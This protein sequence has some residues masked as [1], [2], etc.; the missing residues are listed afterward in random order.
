M[1]HPHN[2]SFS[3]KGSLLPSIVKNASRNCMDV[4]SDL[5]KTTKIK[6]DE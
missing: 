6:T 4:P 2:K 1:K 3:A 5:L